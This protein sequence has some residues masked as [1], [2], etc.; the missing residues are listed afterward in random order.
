MYGLLLFYTSTRN[1]LSKY[2]PVIKFFSIKSI[3]FLSFWQGKGR[4]ARGVGR[5]AM[6][7]ERLGMYIDCVTFSRSSFN[8][9]G[10]V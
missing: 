9:P 1:L 5:G 10:V 6:G 8:Y 4:G 3:V 7:G 2:N